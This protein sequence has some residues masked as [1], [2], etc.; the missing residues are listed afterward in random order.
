MVLVRFFSYPTREPIVVCR[1]ASSIKLSDLRLLLIA[2]LSASS[3]N[4]QPLKKVCRWFWEIEEPGAE[5]GKFL[6]ITNEE[7]L[8]DSLG[9]GK[10]NK[11]YIEYSCQPS[12]TNS[13]SESLV[14]IKRERDEDET[15]FEEETRH[16]PLLNFPKAEL[17]RMSM[18]ATKKAD[19][20]AIR[21]DKE[22]VRADKEAIRADK[23]AT[24]ADKETA[25]ADKEAAKAEELEKKVICLTA[26][27]QIS[28]QS[29][30]KLSRKLV[31]AL[32]VA[33]KAQRSHEETKAAL[34]AAQEQLLATIPAVALMRYSY[35]PLVALWLVLNDKRLEGPSAAMSIINDPRCG[36]ERRSNAEISSTF[37]S[38]S[39]VP[40]RTASPL[41][42]AV[43]ANRLDVV[44]SIVNKMRANPNSNNIWGALDD[45]QS[46]YLAAEC[47]HWD[48]LKYLAN[49]KDGS[50]NTLLHAAVLKN[51]I[52]SI[53]ML[54]HFK[55][56]I[57]ATDA[58]GYTAL[59]YAVGYNNVEAVRVL[60]DAFADVTIRGSDGRTAMDCNRVPIS[61]FDNQ[62]LAAMSISSLMQNAQLRRPMVRK[63]IKIRSIHRPTK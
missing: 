60:L 53:K 11:F 10:V 42:L 38:S 62:Y 55:A 40:P 48:I 19:K 4:G 13:F 58:I 45:T 26:A 24:R 23:E 3:D 16:L 57:N 43:L 49:L 44:K 21:A 20:E 33:Q 1:V 27:H 15:Y 41:C 14:G 18:D 46:L 37:R 34:A 47:G 51:Q 52:E 7:D 61:I 30:D 5:A 12:A 17:A 6:E 28:L 8:L 9:E 54:L 35:Q 63:V 29:T 32:A 22:A 25:R 50:G 39:G 36:L 59:H 2:K 56:N 31:K